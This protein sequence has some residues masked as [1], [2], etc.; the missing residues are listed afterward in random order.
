MQTLVP[1]RTKAASPL[2]RRARAHADRV[3][4]ALGPPP[5]ESEGSRAVELLREAS[6]RVTAGR[7]AILEL[8]LRRKGPLSAAEVHEA[9]GVRAPDRV[10]IYRSLEALAERGLISVVVATDR[11]RRY[12]FRR[13][14]GEARVRFRCLV[15]K[16][17]T[18]LPAVLPV[19]TELGNCS[20]ERQTLSVS[21]VCSSCR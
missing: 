7:I 18:V 21:G 14:N 6:T 10:T 3:G 15:C 1:T 5:Q 16:G 17:I 9:L 8:L 4:S 20:I 13:T 2:A 19:L 11:I 12:V